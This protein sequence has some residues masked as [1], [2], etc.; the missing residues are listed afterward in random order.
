MRNGKELVAQGYRQLSRA[1]RMV[2]RLPEGKTGLEALAEHDPRLAADFKARAEDWATEHY[3]R[4]YARGEPEILE[5]S[6]EEFKDFYQAKNGTPTKLDPRK[7][8]EQ[9]QHP[10]HGE[11]G[12][13]ED[14]P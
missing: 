9:S 6:D 5:L 12:R 7:V 8:R 11:V 1:Y 2:G 3:L 4:T 14:A 13:K 10:S